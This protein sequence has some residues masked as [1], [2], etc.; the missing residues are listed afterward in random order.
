MTISN[1]YIT[2]QA[3]KDYVGDG[4]Q[5]DRDN[6]AIDNAVN[7]A[8]RLIDQHCKR[9]FYADGSAT[10][11]TYWPLDSRLCLVDDIST[12]TGLVVKVDRG[13]DGTYEETVSSSDYQLMPLNGVVDGLS[14][15]PYTRIVLPGTV[16]YPSKTALRPPVQVTANWGWAAVPDAVEQACKIIAHQLFAMKDA[17]FGVSVFGADGFTRKVG[18]IPTQAQEL[19][20]LYRRGAAVVGAIA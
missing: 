10:A 16:T 9:R 19:L 4:I 20:A 1:G 13:D 12:T 3:L 18:T 6:D 7:A 2:Q 14:G 15:W 8:S 17:A 5:G 11:R